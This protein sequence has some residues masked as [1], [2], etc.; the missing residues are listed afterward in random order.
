MPHGS[1]GPWPATDRPGVRYRHSGAQSTEMT[2]RVPPSP[3]SLRPGKFLLEY[4]EIN[5]RSKYPISI[6]QAKSPPDETTLLNMSSTSPPGRRQPLR[7][8][9]VR[10]FPKMVLR[11]GPGA[12][13]PAAEGPT[14]TPADL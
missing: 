4:F 14:P 1:A 3:S 10:P 13:P 11:S 12:G 2:S 6:F 5:P 7:R 9:V 8:E